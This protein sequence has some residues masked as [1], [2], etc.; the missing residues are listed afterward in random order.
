VP[1]L[2]SLEHRSLL[3]GPLPLVNHFLRRLRLR[4]ILSAHVPSAP[5][6]RL[7]PVT[8]LLLLV[9][10]ILLSREPLYALP[11]WADPY[12]PDLLDLGPETASLLN[13]DR[14]ARALDALFD[15]D[16][17]SLLTAIVVRAL[18]EFHVAL[19]RVHNDSTTLTLRGA[20]RGAQGQA[21]RGKPTSRAARGHNKEHRPDLKQ[22]LSIFTVSSDGAVPV[23]YRLE[24]GNTN[25][26][27][28]H[29]ESWEAIRTLRGN[30]DFLYVADCSEPH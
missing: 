25:D 9:R 17:A 26:A 18:S 11:E 22:L 29:R 10:N 15:A 21:V 13:D 19:D 1:D 27:P 24:D 5:E 30:P 16:R 28:T 8:A 20:Y 14:I 3:L 12:R 2:D 4:E 6:A 7:D 23:S